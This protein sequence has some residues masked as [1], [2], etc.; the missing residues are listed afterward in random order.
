VTTPALP[1]FQDGVLTTASMLNSVVSNTEALYEAAMGVPQ[2]G[3]Y[4]TAN[5]PHVVLS[6]TG[7]ASSV[8]TAFNNGS[9]IPG[10]VVWDTAVINTDAMWTSGSL[11]TV[12]TAGTYRLGVQLQVNEPG[13]FD[14]AGGFGIHIYLMVN[15]TAF[16]TNTI[17]CWRG[18]FG[19]AGRTSA[20]ASLLPGAT[21]S[22]FALYDYSTDSSARHWLT[23]QGGT[24]FEAIRLGPA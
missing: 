16:A 20:I 1:T 21:I 2:S 9:R 12:N 22:V 4:L 17:G 10:A 15:G 23:T 11:I 18:F 24:R 8:T 5:K 3:G 13:G 19:T 7:T 14:G 6:I